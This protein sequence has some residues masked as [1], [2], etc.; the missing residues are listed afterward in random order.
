MPACTTGDRDV[1][2][3][4]GDFTDAKIF[5]VLITLQRLEEALMTWKGLDHPN[6]AHVFGTM[7]GFG[8]LPAVVM[9]FYEPGNVNR[10]IKNNHSADILFLV[11]DL[12]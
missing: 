3:K 6:I 7:E 12:I 11:R 10:Y 1:F 4:A 8:R 2:Y 5:S 9:P